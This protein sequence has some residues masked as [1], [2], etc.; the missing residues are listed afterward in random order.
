[1]ESTQQLQEA[2][3]ELDRLKERV[4]HLDKLIGEKN[5]RIEKEEDRRKRLEVCCLPHDMSAVVSGFL[6][7]A[8][9][10]FFSNEE[11]YMGEKT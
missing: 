2:R 6:L 7:V 9:Y 8:T 10:F 4:E 3:T 1:M 11:K 5:E